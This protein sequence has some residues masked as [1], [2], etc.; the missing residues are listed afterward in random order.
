[1]EALFGELG[2]TFEKHNNRKPVLV[3]KKQTYNLQ[4]KLCLMLLNMKKMVAMLQI[5]EE[6]I[7]TAWCRDGF[8]YPATDNDVE[9]PMEYVDISTLVED[10]NALAKLQQEFLGLD[11]GNE[12]TAMDMTTAPNRKC[13]FVIEIPQVKNTRK[14]Q[15]KHQ[16]DVDED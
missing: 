6:P 7:H 11:I 2:S 14:T 5:H 3:D 15:R 12:D 8:E 10:G 16:M 1:M 4:L 13:N 9:Q